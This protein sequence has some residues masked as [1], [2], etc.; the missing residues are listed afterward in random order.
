MIAV[1]VTGVYALVVL[2]F[3]PLVRRLPRSTTAI[4]ILRV[5]YLDGH[6]ILRKVLGHATGLGFVVAEVATQSVGL[7]RGAFGGRDTPIDGDEPP[8]VEVTLQIHGR[9]SVEQLAAELSEFPG[10]DAVSGGDANNAGE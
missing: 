5:R 6:G 3:P 4:S 1:F 8:L 10:V 7:G 2:A 9:G